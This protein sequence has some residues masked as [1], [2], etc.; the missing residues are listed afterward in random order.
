MIAGSQGG[1]KW[2]RKEIIFSL[3]NPLFQI[4]TRFLL[5]LCYI[6]NDATRQGKTVFI[7]NNVKS[8]KGENK[9]SIK[10]Q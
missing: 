1:K 6:L 10:F 7:V 3:R 2:L 9:K 8:K 4:S 5:L